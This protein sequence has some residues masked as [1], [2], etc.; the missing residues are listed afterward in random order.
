[1]L[2][3][4]LRREADAWSRKYQFMEANKQ[5]SAIGHR[6]KIPDIQKTLDMVKFLKT[7]KVCLVEGIRGLGADWICSLV[8]IQ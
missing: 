2:D 3:L 4:G 1:L 8:R 7:R 6:E 5:R